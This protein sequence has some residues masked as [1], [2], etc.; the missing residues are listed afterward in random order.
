VVLKG[1]K[2]GHSVLLYSLLI[3]LT[4]MTAGL[5]ASGSLPIL[6]NAPR[7]PYVGR[8]LASIDRFDWTTYDLNSVVRSQVLTHGSRSQKG[9]SLHKAT[10]WM[11]EL[12]WDEHYIIRILTDA[13]SEIGRN[14]NGAYKNESG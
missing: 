9:L 12:P 5:S 10:D 2:F 13:V 3:I 1:E 8:L 14:G 6:P 4:L 11:P 7:S